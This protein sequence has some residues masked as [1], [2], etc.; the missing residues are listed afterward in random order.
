MKKSN[1][2]IEDFLEYLLIDKKCSIH[3]LNS[4]KNELIR[5]ISF[6][7][8]NK[9][10][11]ENI[12]K[13][14][15]LKYLKYLNS[16]KLNPNSISHNIS[17]IRSFYKFLAIVNFKYKNPIDYFKLPKK[18]KTLP[19]VLSEDE[20]EQLLNI[21]S[22]DN[23]SIR[24]K[25]MLEL[26]YSSGLRVSE[27]LSLKLYSIDLVENVLR[28]EGKGSKERMIPIGD[29]A[30][31]Y[32]NKY[33]QI[34]DSL[35]KKKVSDSLFLNS[36]GENMSRQGFFKIVKKIAKEK[37]IKKDISPHILRHSFA[38]HLLKH[39]ADLRIIQ[40]LLGHSDLSTTQIYTHIE[41]QNLK[42]NYNTFHPHGG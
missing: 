27:L 40:E 19:K 1:K 20:V 36:R 17:V 12:K 4:Y 11:C 15:T 22:K 2:N 42:D 13:E 37:G 38:S 16:E 23:Y 28:T 18:A 32:L 34:R 39:G 29:I 7:E 14:D 24:N 31:H 41:N 9:L 25:A 35:L 8:K 21:E 3:T 6:L 33:L 5:Y 30:M 26:M 10:D